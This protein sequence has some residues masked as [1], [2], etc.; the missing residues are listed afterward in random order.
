MITMNKV[1]EKNKTYSCVVYKKPNFNF[2][3]D[4]LK[5]EEWS[6]IYYADIDQ[7]KTRVPISILNKAKFRTRNI[8]SNKKRPS[9]M[10]KGSI[11]HY[12]IAILNVCV[13]KNC[14]SK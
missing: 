7:K 1:D 3:T 4:R 5:V 11:L 13:P 12:G 14:A 10:I 9:I 2:K 8:V 6:K